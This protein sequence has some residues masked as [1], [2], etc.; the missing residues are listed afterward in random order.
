MTKSNFF[1]LSTA[2]WRIAIKAVLFDIIK[3]CFRS[4][5][6]VDTKNMKWYLS[7][8]SHM[9]HMTKIHYP[10]CL[11]QLPGMLLPTVYPFLLIKHFECLHDRYVSYF[12]LPRYILHKTDISN[13][14]KTLTTWISK[15]ETDQ[16]I[17]NASS[18]HSKINY[19][20]GIK[21]TG[22]SRN[23]H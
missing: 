4:L 2:T 6:S 14:A 11:Y 16:L 10:A 22:G 23:L 12:L 20:V 5:V 1:L 7:F 19:T 15:S 18:V 3:P 21:F 9:P 13:T 17:H 8:S